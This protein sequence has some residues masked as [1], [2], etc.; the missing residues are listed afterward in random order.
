MSERLS[1]GDLGT[2]LGVWAHP[3]DE[4]Y[5]SA[6]LMAAAR[7]DG[8]RVVVATATAGEAGTSD[9]QRW[10]PDRL[11]ALRRHELVAS[12]AVAGV[13]EHHWLGFRDGTCA[14]VTGGAGPAAVAKLIEEV[15]PDTI[16]TFGPDGMTGHSDHQ[17]IS[18][19]TTQA[20]LAT[21]TSARLLYATLTPEFHD[22][23]GALNQQIGLWL[24]GSGPTTHGDELALLLELSDDA[25]DRKLAALRAH[26][27]QTAAL[28]HDVG[29]E[30]FRRW[31]ACEAFVA[32]APSGANALASSAR[33][34]TR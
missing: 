27:S 23:W 18:A 14:E 22:T 11:A 8:G 9:P 15:A 34:S 1:V 26:A 29:E 25:Q 4:A 30:V 10:G 2:L 19:W 7:A 33:T 6:G 21:G 28:V 3:D 32:A 17:A 13:V 24:S 31:W 5:L 16:I 12:L 20:W